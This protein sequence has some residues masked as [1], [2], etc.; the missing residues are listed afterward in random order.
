MRT[1]LGTEMLERLVCPRK[2][3][4]DIMQHCH[5][6]LDAVFVRLFQRVAKVIS[7]RAVDSSVKIPAL[8]GEHEVDLTPVVLGRL[9]RHLLGLHHRVD[10]LGDR[11]LGNSEEPGHLRR[12]LRAALGEQTK[13]LYF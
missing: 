3:D 7:L 5:Q 12:S 10:D 1:A 6:L 9:T 11:R 4:A 13:D 8:A 2:G